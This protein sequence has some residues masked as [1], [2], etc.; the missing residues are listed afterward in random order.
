M[1]K[2][3]TRNHVFGKWE[4]YF[5]ANPVW[6]WHFMHRL[7]FG[8]NIDVYEGLSINIGLGLISFSFIAYR[9]VSSSSFSF[10]VF[11]H[12]RGMINEQARRY[13]R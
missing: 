10:W 5:E 6:L 1:S 13:P 2:W 8:I 7:Y 4:F 11:Q 12:Y 3:E 9:A